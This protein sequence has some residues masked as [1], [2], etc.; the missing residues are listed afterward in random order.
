MLFLMQTS[1]I[2]HRAWNR[3]PECYGLGNLIAWGF[4]TA[5]GVQCLVL[6]PFDILP[7]GVGPLTGNFRVD[8]WHG[9][10]TAALTC[11][12]LYSFKFILLYYSSIICRK[13]NIHFCNM[14]NYSFSPIQLQIEDFQ[15][16][17]VTFI[18]FYRYCS[19]FIFCFTRVPVNQDK[20]LICVLNMNMTS[21]VQS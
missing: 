21:W 7:G 16:F 1:P 14:W 20:I 13:V 19:V 15:G 17:P 6:G 10:A 18:R 9:W 4:L 8:G 3:H 2:L 12:W 11:C 5:W